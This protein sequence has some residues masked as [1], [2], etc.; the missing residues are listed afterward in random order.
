MQLVQYYKLFMLFTLF[1]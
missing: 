1:L